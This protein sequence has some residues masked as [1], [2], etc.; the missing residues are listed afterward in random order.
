MSDIVSYQSHW[1]IGLQNL[2]K[3]AI[4]D[5]RNKKKVI[6]GK[7]SC[8]CRSTESSRNK[9]MVGI[10]PKKTRSPTTHRSPPTTHHL[11]AIIHY[12]PPSVH[13][14]L[15]TTHHTP[16][17]RFFLMEDA[18]QNFCKKKLKKF[19]LNF[20]YFWSIGLTSH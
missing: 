1:P 11:L 20:D 10:A 9:L 16:S 8:V 14:P 18:P 4:F 13:H 3:S 7:N 5:L 17:T 12:P 19:T 15:P 2:P 6:N